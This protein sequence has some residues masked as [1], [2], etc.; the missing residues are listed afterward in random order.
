MFALFLAL[1]AFWLDKITDPYEYLNKLL[2]N[3]ETIDFD[4]LKNE[5]LNLDTLKTSQALENLQR[6]ILNDI[7]ELKEKNA[8]VTRLINQQEEDFEHKKNLISAM[9]HDLK[10]P[11]T[12]INTTLSAMRDGIIKIEDSKDDILMMIKEVEKTSSM[13][14]NMINIYKY[15][16]DLKEINKTDISLIDLINEVCDELDSLFNKY[17]QSL[18]VNYQKDLILNTDH[19]QFKRVLDNLVMNAIVHSPNKNQ[20]IINLKENTLEI[21]NTGVTISQD[22]LKK[23]FEPFY[24]VDEARKEAESG[25]GLGL[26]IVNEICKRLGYK[27]AVSS[28]N[29]KTTFTITF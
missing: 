1:D 11:L 4:V 5:A 23:I 18:S 29:N 22:N 14:Q 16:N 21:I 8:T 3:I 10:T 25:N 6:R 12:I 9:S 24:K 13:L 20:V 26:Y 2:L 27:I 7:N 28:K 17:E 19:N 15:D